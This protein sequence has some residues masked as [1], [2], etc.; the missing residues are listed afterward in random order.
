MRTVSF[1]PGTTKSWAEKIKKPTVMS[2]FLY[3]YSG[4][5]ILFSRQSPFQNTAHHCALTHSAT[6]AH[7][8]RKTTFSAFFSS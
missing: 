2:V 4:A 6:S 1:L 8:P 7:S 3:L 5:T